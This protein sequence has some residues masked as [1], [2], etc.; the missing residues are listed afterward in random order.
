MKR[1][2]TRPA[3]P[4][5]ASLFAPFSDRVICCFFCFPS[6]RQDHDTILFVSNK[7]VAYG[8]RAFQVP[9]GSRTAKGVPVPQVRGC[10]RMRFLGGEMNNFMR[11]H[12]AELSERDWRVV[13][14][15]VPGTYLWN[16]LGRFVFLR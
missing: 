5:L 4:P 10:W 1:S 9:I 12:S 11:Y 15:V 8:I 13:L 7:G 14:G 6:F 2:V 3:P 16:A